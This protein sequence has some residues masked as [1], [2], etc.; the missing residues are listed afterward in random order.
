MSQIVRCEVCGG[1]YNQRYLRAHK[2]LSHERNHLGAKNEPE[3]L[4]AIVSLYTQLSDESK[5]MLRDRLANPV[6]EV[7]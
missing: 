2:R 7:V 3:A 5:R 1:V 4:K 6:G